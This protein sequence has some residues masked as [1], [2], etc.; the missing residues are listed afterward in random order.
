MQ[1]AHGL[2]RIH[3]SG[4][5]SSSSTPNACLLV[6]REGAV[7]KPSTTVSSSSGVRF[8]TNVITRHLHR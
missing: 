3:S 6:G 8:Y 5:S 1:E 2:R 7:Y 4:C